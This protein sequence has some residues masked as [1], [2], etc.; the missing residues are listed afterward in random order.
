MYFILPP[1]ST[2]QSFQREIEM[3][4]RPVRYCTGCLSP[5]T[6][7]S[8]RVRPLPAHLRVAWPLP[9]APGPPVA[10]G[11]QTGS[12]ECEWAAW[13]NILG[14]RTH[15]EARETSSEGLLGKLRRTGS[16]NKPP[17]SSRASFAAV[18]SSVG[19][20]SRIPCVYL[21]GAGGH[22]PHR[23]PSTAGAQASGVCGSVQTSRL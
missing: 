1:T 19:I 16:G 6:F 18:L 7:K 3:F 20:S 4:Q 14:E 15:G 13:E 21:T 10:S 5:N 9:N 8:W 12:R 2:I 23:A 17:L 11:P 22:R